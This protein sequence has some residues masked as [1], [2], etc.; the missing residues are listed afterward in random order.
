MSVA[1]EKTAQTFLNIV[2]NTDIPCDWPAY[3]EDEV[4]VIYGSESLYAVRDVDFTVTLDDGSNFNQ[5]VV[6]PLAPLLT[7]I[8]NLIAADPTN[9]SNFI[10]VRR[11]LDYKTSVTPEIVRSVGFLSREID[12]IAMRFQQIAEAGLRVVGLAPKFVGD[13]DAPLYIEETPEDGKLLIGS[14]N[15]GIKN[16]PDA[17]D[18]ADAQANGVIATNAA[19]SAS[20][21]ATLASNWA[22][23]VGAFVT[24]SLLSAREWAVGTFRRGFAGFG[25]AKDWAVYTGGTVDDVDYSAKYHAALA[26]LSASTALN[27]S[28]FASGFVN[29]FRNPGMNIW[30]RGD[31]TN[32]AGGS[33]NTY[34][35]DGWILEP[36]GAVCHGYIGGT[37]GRSANSMQ[38]VGAS[39]LTNTRLKQRIEAIE[40]NMLA[41]RRCTV[42]MQIWNANTG[43]PIT[44]TINIRR[45]NSIDNF[46]GGMTDIVGTVN[47]QT[48]ANGASAVVAYTFDAG[49]GVD[50]GLEVAIDFGA[51]LNLNTKYVY[52]SD[53]DIRPT[54]GATLGLN[55]SPQDVELRPIPI[56]Q[57]W[58]ARY[59]PAFLYD[60]PSSYTGIKAS[61]ISSTGVRLEWSWRV[62]TRALVSGFGGTLNSTDF[63]ASDGAGNGVN[64]T[65]S[66]A[67]GSA[68]R[69]SALVIG[70]T[71]GSLTAGQVN[72]ISITSG[73]TAG[74]VFFTGAEL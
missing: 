5:F 24:G 61:N 50:K 35:T 28:A 26:A 49:T 20:A 13:P 60:T 74:R 62:R 22:Q 69:E 70:T 45:P 36:V 64:F 40:S 44:P 8:N 51:A 53:A 52:V 73:A 56:E 15:G 42:R 4:F 68:T 58:C 3:A 21:S 32:I 59:L 12:R 67:F 72:L 31:V 9:E 57:D 1:T 47:L 34:T 55:N 23:Q 39:G 43:G 30:S 27:S 38:I 63:R 41:G 18:I 16:G 14:V 37:I 29:K 19:N 7:K 2:V 17:G 11:I 46:T 25:S 66:F 54:P 10:T 48:I 6:T 65:G 33:L 71:A